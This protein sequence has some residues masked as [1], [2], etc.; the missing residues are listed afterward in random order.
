MFNGL[1]LFWQNTEPT[2]ANLGHY[3][4]NFH[5]CK[6]QYLK[7]YSH[8]VTVVITWAILKSVDLLD[9]KTT[10]LFYVN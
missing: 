8:L 7:K 6:W 1:F 4:A 10:S 9:S 2:L 3:W 5:C